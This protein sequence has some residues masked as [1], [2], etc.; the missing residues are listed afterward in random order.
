Q[1][2]IIIGVLPV[3]ANVPDVDVNLFFGCNNESLDGASLQ[4]R[5]WYHRKAKSVPELAPA[6]K[7]LD[8]PLDLCSVDIAN[9]RQNRIVR[10]IVAAVEVQHVSAGQ[11]FHRFHVT[12][13]RAVLWMA[14]EDYLVEYVRSLHPRH[15]EP[16]LYLRDPPVYVLFDFALGELR[17]LHQVGRYL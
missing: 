5:R 3:D 6:K 8:S 14:L 7:I 15:I 16:A 4:N 1:K 17:V 10:N 9:D 2:R 13:G 11:V 12:D